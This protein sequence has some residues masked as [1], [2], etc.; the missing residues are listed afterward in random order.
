MIHQAAIDVV[1]SAIESELYKMK[2]AQAQLE[3][4]EQQVEKNLEIL[5]KA[6]AEQY[7][8][9]RTRLMLLNMEE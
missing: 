9:N 8:L 6:N 2:Q 3:F 7:S 5:Q 1:D 4:H